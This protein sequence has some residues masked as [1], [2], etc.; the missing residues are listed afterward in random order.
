[1]ICTYIHLIYISVGFE[2]SPPDFPAVVV[3]KF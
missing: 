2:E 3:G 1:M